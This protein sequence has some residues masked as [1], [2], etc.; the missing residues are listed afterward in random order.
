MCDNFQLLLYLYQVVAS[1]D[2]NIQFW[3]SS[4]YLSFVYL[5]FNILRQF[6]LLIVILRNV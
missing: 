4:F 2:P 3:H 6:Q 5:F 1:V